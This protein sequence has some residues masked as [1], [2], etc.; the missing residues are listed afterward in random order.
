M[1]QNER[2]KLSPIVPPI[3]CPDE[4]EAQEEYNRLFHTKIVIEPIL[5][6]LEAFIDYR[7]RCE[8][9]LPRHE[10]T[11]ETVWS[12]NEPTLPFRGIC[13]NPT[14]GWDDSDI[15]RI[16]APHAARAPRSTIHRSVLFPDFDVR[17]KE[18]FI[19]V[20]GNESDRLNFVVGYDRQGRVLANCIPMIVHEDSNRFLESVV[21]PSLELQELSLARDEALL[22]LHSESGVAAV[23]EFMATFAPIDEV[24][25]PIEVREIDVG[26]MLPTAEKRVHK[27]EPF[28]VEPLA[29]Y[30]T[31]HTRNFSEEDIHEF[32][33]LFPTIDMRE[34][35]LK[36][37]VLMRMG[38]TLIVLG[39]IEQES[40]DGTDL[41]DCCLNFHRFDGSTIFYGC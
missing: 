22:R 41:I 39:Q 10:L 2:W 36:Q 35:A 32:G 40:F 38:T 4:P 23:F 27:E 20:P 6:N 24:V 16:V 19:D 29:R 25:S 13:L 5:T 12:F 28:E 37:G 9:P 8:S 3:A 7:A 1:T 21:I 11:F 30:M 14:F 17:A 31:I 18:V 33:D 15:E 34:D 26:G